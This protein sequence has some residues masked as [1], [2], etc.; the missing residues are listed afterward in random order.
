MSKLD[1]VKAFC[2]DNKGGILL[3]IGLLTNAACLITAC[4]STAKATD[5]LDDHDEKIDDI[6]TDKDLDRIDEDE[7]KKLSRD[8]Y[9]H[10]A[11]EMTKLYAGPVILGVVSFGT[12]IA[13]Y[14]VERS[15]R[16]KAVAMAADAVAKAMAVSAAFAKY[17]ERVIERYGAEVDYDIYNGRT[18]T[19]SEVEVVD[20]K[21]GKKKKKKV[22]TTT[23]DPIDDN[24]YAIEWGRFTSLEWSTDPDHNLFYT[25]QQLKNLE[26]KMNA[27]GWV[28]YND[29]CEYFGIDITVGREQTKRFIPNSIMWISEKVF[30]ELPDEWVYEGKHYVKSDYTSKIDLG[31]DPNRI[32]LAKDYAFHGWEDE[33]YF[34]RPNCYPGDKILE[35]ASKYAASGKKAA[36]AVDKKTLKTYDHN[37]N[38]GG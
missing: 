23:S 31:I 18:V 4:I 15:E 27:I 32:E 19:E 9:K 16:E 20:P 34:F 25:N 24:I 14:K 28:T 10:T 36:L 21:T 6:N 8:I 33:S 7:A 29:M 17:R 12:I 11:W 5:I 1:N 38:F 3:T 30:A 2:K 22:Y 13:G 37:N 26:H 35:F